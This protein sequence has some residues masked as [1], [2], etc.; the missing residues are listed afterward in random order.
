MR[1]N[2]TISIYSFHNTVFRPRVGGKQFQ[3][4][5]VSAVPVVDLGLGLGSLDQELSGP[6]TFRG[7]RHN[8]AQVTGGSRSLGA[9]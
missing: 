8:H 9:V 6:S 3:V 5:A 1:C 4:S 7:T 2:R